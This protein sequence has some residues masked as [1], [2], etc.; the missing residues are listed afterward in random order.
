MG[1][2]SGQNAKKNLK[3]IFLRY[4]VQ[5]DSGG[6]DYKLIVNYIHSNAIRKGRLMM[7]MIFACTTCQLTQVPCNPLHFF[8]FDFAC[9]LH[10]HTCMHWHRHVALDVFSSW[11]IRIIFYDKC[12]FLSCA[13]FSFRSN[14]FSLIKKCQCWEFGKM[15]RDND[16]EKGKIMRLMMR[17]QLLNPLLLIN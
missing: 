16:D 2:S 1:N 11:E 12:E 7:M 3:R 13:C 14:Y 5:F 8:A 15:S 6:D 17:C 10:T 9:I 4:D